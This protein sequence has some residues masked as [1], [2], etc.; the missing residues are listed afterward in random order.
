MFITSI[1]VEEGMKTK[2]RKKTGS[3]RGRS[4]KGRMGMG[5]WNE[6]GPVIAR[7]SGGRS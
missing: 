7:L 2:K 4:T 1:D 5:Q 6:H 3:M